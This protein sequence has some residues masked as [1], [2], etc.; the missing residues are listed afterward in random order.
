M[1]GGGS[2]DPDHDQVAQERKVPTIGG[3]HRI[4]RIIDKSLRGVWKVTIR[5]CGLEARS[6]SVCPKP[7]V[8]ETSSDTTSVSGF[9]QLHPVPV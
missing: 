2:S 6:T 5:E 8:K 3:E 1:L 4:T 9:T 7:L